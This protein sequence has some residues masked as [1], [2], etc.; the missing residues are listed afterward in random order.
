MSRVRSIAIVGAGIAG[1]T[2][3]IAARAAGVEVVVLEAQK[4]SPRPAQHFE[5]VPNLLRDLARLGL[6]DACIAAGFPYNS[7]TLSNVSRSVRLEIPLRR[8]AAERYPPALGIERGALLGI[9]A[10][11][12]IE[13][14]AQVQRGA[15]VDARAMGLDREPVRPPDPPLADADLVVLAAG[16]ESPLRAALF[17]AAPTSLPGPRPWWCTVVPRPAGVDRMQIIVDAEHRKLFMLPLDSTRAGL[18]LIS[19]LGMPPAGDGPID[20]TML[21]GQIEAFGQLSPRVL[22][23]LDATHPVTVWPVRDAILPA[24]WYRDRILCVGECAHALVPHFGQSAAMAVE[25]ALVLG[26]LLADGVDV[27]RLLERFMQRR[28]PRVRL[29]QALTSRAAVWERQPDASTDLGQLAVEIAQVVA[30]PA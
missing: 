12:A 10:Q 2:C 23:A 14:G 27:G 6:A 5:V 7:W 25:D 16:A 9:L 19:D 24:P 29:L 8:L 22:A 1:L 17:P 4:S 30:R 3:A 21:R 26:E 11:S 28:E 18:A 15:R 13:R 20:A